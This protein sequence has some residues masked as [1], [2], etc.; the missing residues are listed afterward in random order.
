M[1]HDVDPNL[2]VLKADTQTDGWIG[3]VDRLI[4]L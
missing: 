4:Y 2:Y 1:N 3:N